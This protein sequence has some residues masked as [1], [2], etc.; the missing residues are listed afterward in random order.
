[1]QRTNTSCS[2][3]LTHEADPEE[4]CRYNVGKMTRTH[5]GQL[6]AERNRCLKPRNLVPHRYSATR[7]GKAVC[8]L[9]DTQSK[10]LGGPQFQRGYDQ[11]TWQSATKTSAP[12]YATTPRH[13][14]TSTTSRTPWAGAV[15]SKVHGS[16]GFAS[17]RNR[18]AMKGRAR[19]K[20][21]TFSKHAFTTSEQAERTHIIN[22]C[23]WLG[24][25][26]TPACENE[27]GSWLSGWRP[28]Q[29]GAEPQLGCGVEGPG[30][31]AFRGT[32]EASYSLRA[33]PPVK[34]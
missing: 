14:A 27:I 24:K 4:W 28:R 10:R 23:V 22:P 6:V 9:R 13:A 3:C 34:R 2:T 16:G 12:A 1:M 31:G 32:P 11:P 21:W 26:D 33:E 20:A 18:G 15:L 19:V 29:R 7:C 30:T 5:P 17:S 25:V 8:S